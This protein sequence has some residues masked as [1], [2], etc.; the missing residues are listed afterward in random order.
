MAFLKIYMFLYK[1]FYVNYKNYKKI[2]KT[3]L[4]SLK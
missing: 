4:T 1:K 3:L 2:L